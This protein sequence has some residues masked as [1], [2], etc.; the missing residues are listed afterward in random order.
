MGWT[1]DNAH[2]LISDAGTSG[3]CPVGGGPAGGEPDGERQEGQDPLPRPGA[4]RSAGAR[5]RPDQAQVFAMFAEMDEEVRLRRA[6]AGHDGPEDA[7]LRGR[8]DRRAAEGREG[9]RLALPPRD[10][11]A[12]AADLRDRRVAR[13]RPEDRGHVAAE[14]RPYPVDVGR[15]APRRITNDHPDPKERQQLQASLY[16]PA[17]YEKGKH[18]PD[19]RLHLRAA[20]AGPQPVR[21]ADG[22]RLQPPGLHEQRLRGAAAGH[23]VLRQRSRHVGGVGARAG[24]AG[25]DQDRRRRSE[26]RRPARP[27]VGRLPDGVHD[28]ADGHLRRGDR[29]RAADEHDQH[30]FDHLQEQ[31]RHERRDLREQPGPLH[32]RAVGATGR[33]T[34]ATRRSLTRRT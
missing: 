16:L 19:D 4:H 2:V 20:D 6:R 1:S 24:G 7:D 8:V 13:E 23:Q 11:D 22:E 5:H 12:G 21:P 28:H 25:G 33:P 14:A 31:R 29:R 34:R 9:G 10:A 26:A 27:L 3:R 32:R 15:A 18:V 30:V 17:N